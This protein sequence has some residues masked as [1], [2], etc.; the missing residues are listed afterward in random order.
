VVRGDA[1]G[2]AL[3]EGRNG[4]QRVDA[5]GSRDEGAIADVQVAIAIAI[6]IAIAVAGGAACPRLDSSRAAMKP[7]QRSGPSAARRGRRA[8]LGPVQPRYRPLA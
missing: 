7:A 5:G 6:A 3:G 4:D 1:G 2:L 8:A